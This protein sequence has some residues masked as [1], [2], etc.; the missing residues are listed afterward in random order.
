MEQNNNKYIKAGIIAFLMMIC[1]ILGN[2]SI[3]YGIVFGKDKDKYKYAISTVEKYPELTTLLEVRDHIEKLYNGE[4][5]SNA[6][7]ENAT[8]ALAKTLDDPYTLYMNE[9]E[10]TKY[11]ESNSGSFMGIGV[12]LSVEDSNVV[13]TGIIE[14]GGAEAAGIKEGDIIKS[15]DNKEISGDLNKAVSLLSGEEEELLKLCIYR[16]NEGEFEAEVKRSRIETVA[17]QGEMLSNNVGY[18]K[19]KNFS[20][21]SSVQFSQKLEELLNNGMKGLVLDLRDNGGGYLN[22]AINIASEF[23]PK[24]KT[25]TYTIDKYNKKIVY[26]SNG[27]KITDIPVTILINGNSASASEVLTGALRDYEIA[28]TV[29]T[30]SFG[31]GIVQEIF[32]LSSGEGGFKV[33][34]SKYYTPDG[35][36]IHKT[37]I[38]P[39]FEIELSQDTDNQLEKALEV[40]ENKIN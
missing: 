10:F 13:V 24:N 25:V 1:F 30:T 23:I 37:G 39:N 3:R 35:E 28:Q 19:L 40:M 32:K 31:K 29:G 20:K 34:I 17:V 38:T 9:E 12:Y 27:D 11:M 2:L 16:E 22:E 8:K 6:L 33:T 7:A 18:I 5:N 14:G 15:V 4:I 36:N 21:N 26:K